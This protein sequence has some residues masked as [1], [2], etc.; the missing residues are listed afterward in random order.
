MKKRKKHK[1]K[2]E[3]RDYHAYVCDEPRC[4]FRGKPAVQGGCTDT[5]PFAEKTTWDYVR[6]VEKA[7]MKMLREI[8]KAYSKREYLTY[9]EGAFVTHEMGD[10]FHLDEMVEL[11]RRVALAEYKAKSKRRSA[12]GKRAR[13]G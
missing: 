9:L 11:R 12:M 10:I 3:T 1:T 6:G 2:M 5:E 13:E 7:S 4:K 8:K